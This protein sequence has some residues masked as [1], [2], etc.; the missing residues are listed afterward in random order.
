MTVVTIET[1]FTNQ[2]DELAVRQTDV[3][4]E[5]GGSTQ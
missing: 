2:R 5:P 4:I 1:D 3:L